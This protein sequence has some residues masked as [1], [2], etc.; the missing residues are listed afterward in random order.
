MVNVVQ[1]KIANNKVDFIQTFI[2]AKTFVSQPR[3]LIFAGLLGAPLEGGARFNWNGW[4]IGKATY[5]PILAVRWQHQHTCQSKDRR[6]SVA[7]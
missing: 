3:S 5:E 2:G 1:Q 6:P 7:E 4:N